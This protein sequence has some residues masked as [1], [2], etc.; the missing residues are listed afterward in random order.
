[1]IFAWIFHLLLLE[2]SLPLRAFPHLP[3][4]LHRDLSRRGCS[5]PQQLSPRPH[6]VIT[7]FFSV[8]GQLDWAVLC[9]TK[10]S[11]AI[12]V[13][14]AGDPRSASIPYRTPHSMP[15]SISRIGATWILDHYRAYSGPRP[16]RHITHHGIDLGLNEKASIVFYFHD[17]RWLQLMGA[18]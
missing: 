10:R 9:Q 17:G 5:I 16:P 12:I 8:P 14:F 3:P 4:E 18:D 6:N 11:T 15:R 7:G 2:P 1:M 13:Y